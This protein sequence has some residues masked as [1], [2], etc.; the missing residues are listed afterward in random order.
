MRCHEPRCYLD[1]FRTRGLA[2]STVTTDVNRLGALTRVGPGGGPLESTRARRWCSHPASQRAADWRA[3]RWFAWRAPRGLASRVP[4]VVLARTPRVA[5]R[6][7]WPCAFDRDHRRE[8]LGRSDSR[9][10]RGVPLESTPG[11]ADVPWLVASRQKREAVGAVVELCGLE[12]VDR[13]GS[14]AVTRKARVRRRGCVGAVAVFVQKG[15]TGSARSHP[16][17]RRLYRSVPRHVHASSRFGSARAC[18]AA[19]QLCGRRS[20]SAEHCHAP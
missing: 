1:S 2:P 15:D 18:R 10:P 5:H 8:S 7:A 3:R 17:A 9:R 20:S 12:V 4:P 14:A 6:G 16:A 19:H 13:C 11:A